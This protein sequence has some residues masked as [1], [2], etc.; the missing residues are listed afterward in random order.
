M[1][2]HFFLH[3]FGIFSFYHAWVMVNVNMQWKKIKEK[4]DGLGE[5]RKC[6]WWKKGGKVK[7]R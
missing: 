1:V 5:T 3:F 2:G 7:M 6:K 4:N